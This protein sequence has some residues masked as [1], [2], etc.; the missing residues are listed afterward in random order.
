MKRNES[1]TGSGEVRC[2]RNA[3]ELLATSRW[4]LTR[5][6]PVSDSLGFQLEQH[7]RLRICNG[8]LEAP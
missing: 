5:S 7:L 1:G 2:N 4:A 3:L 6:S 8:T